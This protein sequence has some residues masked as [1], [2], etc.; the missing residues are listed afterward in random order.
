VLGPRVSSGDFVRRMFKDLKYSSYFV[1]DQV[2]ATCAP[3]GD[4]VSRM[5]A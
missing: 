1:S 4:F 3:S 2:F 5:W